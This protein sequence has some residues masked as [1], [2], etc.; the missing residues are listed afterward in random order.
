M[1]FCRECGAQ[2]GDAD[3]FCRACGGAAQPSSADSSTRDNPKRALAGALDISATHRRADGTGGRGRLL[4]TDEGLD[5]DGPAGH[6]RIGT[7]KELIHLD[8]DW[9]S[10]RVMRLTVSSANGVTG[11]FDLHYETYEQ[12]EETALRL[13]AGTDLLVTLHGV[14]LS[15]KEA[16]DELELHFHEDAADSPRAGWASH[17]MQYAYGTP[18]GR[19]TNG[20]AIAGLV[21]AFVFWP[22]GF[23]FGFIA[24]SQ[25]R[26][27]GEGGDGLA[28]AAIVISS[29]ELGLLLIFWLVVVSLVTA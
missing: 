17:P 11:V 2:L 25:I 26:Q 8:F 3:N 27:T 24:K 13:A 7:W 20:F 4:S 9:Q 1:S 29:V 19:Q 28:T 16:E 23:V 12:V 10:K 22:L 6:L 21:C 15:P 14:V 5:F 18:A